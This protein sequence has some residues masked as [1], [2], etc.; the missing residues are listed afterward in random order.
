MAQDRED[1][2]NHS[3][4]SLT[5]SAGGQSQGCKEVTEPKAFQVPPFDSQGGSRRAWLGITLL[6]ITC[7]VGMSA[8]AF[9]LSR[10]FL[11]PLFLFLLTQYPEGIRGLFLSK[12]AW[13]GGVGGSVDRSTVPLDVSLPG[14]RKCHRAWTLHP[15]QTQQPKVRSGPVPGPWKTSSMRQPSHFILQESGNSSAQVSSFKS[16]WDFFFSSR[17]MYRLQILAAQ[18]VLTGI[19]DR[20]ACFVGKQRKRW[21]SDT[22]A[23]FHCSQGVISR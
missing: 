4:P 13:W 7:L 2:P 6:N 11:V 9:R 5:S 22:T 20:K 21:T 15:E 14:L 19:I 23:Q 17:K 12:S 10:H 18:I 1:L 3:S 8:E 16:T